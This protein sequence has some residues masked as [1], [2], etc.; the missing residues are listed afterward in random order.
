LNLFAHYVAIVRYPHNSK[1]A[2]Q[3]LFLLKVFL[4][5]LVKLCDQILVFINKD[6]KNKISLTGSF[7]MEQAL[8]QLLIKAGVVFI[9]D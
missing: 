5:I 9:N 4:S 6:R 8:Y 7:I 3:E 1:T 2:S